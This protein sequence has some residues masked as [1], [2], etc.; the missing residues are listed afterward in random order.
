[1]FAL[2]PMSPFWSSSYRSSMAWS[3]IVQ[4]CHQTPRLQQL[5]CQGQSLGHRALCLRSQPADRHQYRRL[6]RLTDRRC[7]YQALISDVTI[8]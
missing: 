2:K 3:S 1:M 5:V 6:L 4:L 8:P 7:Q